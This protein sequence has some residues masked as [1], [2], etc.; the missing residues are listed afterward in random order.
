MGAS[1][2]YV[3]SSCFGLDPQ[4]N[5]DTSNDVFVLFKFFL[6]NRQRQNIRRLKALYLLIGVIT[7]HF[8]PKATL[9]LLAPAIVLE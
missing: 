7:E 4:Q 5:R 8:T 9:I 6:K 2:L 1:R 3:D